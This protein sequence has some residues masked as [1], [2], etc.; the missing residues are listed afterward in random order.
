MVDDPLRLVGSTVA[1]RYEVRACLTVTGPRVVYQA[2]HVHWSR[3]CTLEVLA[4]SG[5]PARAEQQRRAF[6][7]AGGAVADLGSRHAAPLQVRDAGL[8]DSPMGPVAFVASEAVEGTTLADAIAGSGRTR[9]EPGAV[10]DWMDP[11]LDTMFEAHREGIVHGHFDLE[12]L[13]VLGTLGPRSVFKIDGLVEGAWRPLLQGGALPL[14]QP[15]TGFVA[16]ELGSAD[17]T[18]IGPWTDVFGLASVLSVLLCGSSSAAMRER[19]LPKGVRYAFDKALNQRIDARFKTLAAFRASMMEGLEDVE[20]V[21]ARN[22]R[23]T[24]VVADVDSRLAEGS[25]GGFEVADDG[26]VDVTAPSRGKARVR[27][28]FTQPAMSVP[29]AIANLDAQR[30]ARPASG[31]QP[32]VP[33]KTTPS[34]GFIALLIA[35]LVLAMGGGVAVGYMLFR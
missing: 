22:P 4:A 13:W 15:M 8:H 18:L 31:P 3:P 17:A 28:A 25:A 33:S 19:S 21:R 34:S 12:S 20:D 23:Q 7:K 26:E 30:P 9:F 11:V 2:Q 5:D 35:I 14:R 27:L 10:L 32:T 6:V 24:M 29:D 1:Q 16:P